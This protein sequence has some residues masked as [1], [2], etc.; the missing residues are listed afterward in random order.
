MLEVLLTLDCP[1]NVVVT[2]GPDQPLQ[3]VFLGKSGCHAF[4]MFPDAAR[5]VAG[6]TNV[7]RAIGP[8]GNNIDPPT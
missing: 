4:P 5:E 6:D 1:T 2:L 7:K 3:S 8:I